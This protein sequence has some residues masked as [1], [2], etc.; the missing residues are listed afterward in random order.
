MKQLTEEEFY[1]LV[2]LEDNHLDVN[3]SFD[4]KM[5]ETFGPELEYVK[6]KIKENKVIT[7]IE[8][9]EGMY[10]VSGFHYVNRLG[11]LVNYL[12]TL[13]PFKNNDYDTGRNS[14]SA[15]SKINY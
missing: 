11:Y 12:T 5:F 4:G 3:S 10:Y 1:E 2:E 7:I 8:G 9:D 14:I 6:S 15:L 13:K